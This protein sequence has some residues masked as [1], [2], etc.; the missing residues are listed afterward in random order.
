MSFCSD[1]R[2]PAPAQSP[3]T[4]K[5]GA[6]LQGDSVANTFLGLLGSPAEDAFN[7]DLLRDEPLDR[8]KALLSEAR[9]THEL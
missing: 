9:R 3:R 8:V 6:A 1:K 4:P 2:E 5:S 7:P